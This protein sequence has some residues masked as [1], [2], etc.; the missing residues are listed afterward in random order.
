M[1]SPARSAP[2]SRRRGGASASVAVEDGREAGDQDGQFQEYVDGGGAVEGERIDRIERGAPQGQAPAAKAVQHG[3]E[4]ARTGRHRDDLDPLEGG[5]G[6][7]EQGLRDRIDEVEPGRLDVE[8]GDIGQPAMQP[9]AGDHGV[10]EF[11]AVGAAGE[12]QADG[13]RPQE[14]ED[15][16]QDGGKSRHRPGRRGGGFPPCVTRNPGLGRCHAA[17]RRTCR[18]HG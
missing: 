5:I 8:G 13:G 4:T 7:A 11:V 14:D 6:G 2:T 1:A 17:T 10:E 16:R 18:F 3:E 15:E 12:R 9:L